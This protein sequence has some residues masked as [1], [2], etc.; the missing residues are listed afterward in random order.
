VRKA[1][2][3]AIDKITYS[4]SRKIT[5]PL[6]AFTPEG[7]FEGYPQ[8]KGDNFDPERA[9]QLLGEAGYPVTKKA[10]GT[11]ECKSFPVDQV[12]YNF[13]TQSSNKSMAEF[14]QAQWKQNLG[15][16]VPLKSTE[17][18]TFMAMRSKLEYKGFA[19][20]IWGADYMDPFTFLSLFYT[21]TGD[22]GSGWWDEKY[23]DMLDE[24][25]RTLDKQKRYELLAKAEKFLLDAQPL[26][27]IETLATNWVKKP[28]VK[29]MYPNAGSLFPWKFVYIE[30]DSSK[31]ADESSSLS[32]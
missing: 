30:R 15:V 31:W 13:N 5:K 8:P 4:K 12:D 3:L 9:R 18:K 29:G 2:A 6:S 10:D 22:Q 14:M 28:Y 20:G 19:L 25:N 23:A 26:I 7:I 21:P 17:F 27:P 24:A 1:F 32:E 16:T 11:Y